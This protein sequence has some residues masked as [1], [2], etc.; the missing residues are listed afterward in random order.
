MYQTSLEVLEAAKKLE[1]VSFNAKLVSL[2]TFPTSYR[3]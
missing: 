2:P 3:S 1:E